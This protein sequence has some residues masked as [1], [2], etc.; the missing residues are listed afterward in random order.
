MWKEAVVAEFK[1]LSRYLPGGLRKITK[2]L[3]HGSWYPD[4]EFNSR[5][6]EYDITSGAD[7]IPQ[8]K[9]RLIK[10]AQRFNFIFHKALTHANGQAAES[11]LQLILKHHHNVS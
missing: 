1:V 4:R 5:S 10:S 3:S 7:K 11:T 6:P 2:A 8:P 9:F